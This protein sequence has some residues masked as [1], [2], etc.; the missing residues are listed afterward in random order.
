MK[1]VS[2]IAIAITKNNIVYSFEPGIGVEVPN[3]VAEIILANPYNK[4][5]MFPE[6]EKIPEVTPTIPELKV[7]YDPPIPV[8]EKKEDPIFTEEELLKMP[9]EDLVGLAK[10]MGLQ[11]A[12][13]QW[14][15][16]TLVRKILEV[17]VPNIE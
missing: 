5:I 15:T 8:E 12:N 14:K 3:E 9:K 17:K 11:L 13:S 2:K 4:Q 16:E 7:I 1:L 10:E 6:G